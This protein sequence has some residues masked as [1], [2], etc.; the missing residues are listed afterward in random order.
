M[1][2]LIYKLKNKKSSGYEQVS[3]YMIKIFP[4]A[5]KQRLV[6]F[7]QHMAKNS[8]HSEF[9]IIAKIVTLNRLKTNVSR[10]YHTRPISLLPTH[11]RK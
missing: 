11:F 10:T 7:L 9:S 6:K 1:L 3:N 4:P 8:V 5:Y 2:K